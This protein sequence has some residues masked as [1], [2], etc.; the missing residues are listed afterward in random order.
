MFA[1]PGGMCTGPSVAATRGNVFAETFYLLVQCSND[2][3]GLKHRPS[4]HAVSGGGRRDAVDQAVPHVLSHPAEIR[5]G[6]A[7]AVGSVPLAVVPA[8]PRLQVPLP[9]Q[10]VRVRVAPQ[11]IPRS[12][13]RGQTVATAAMAMA[14]I[15]RKIPMVASPY[16]VSP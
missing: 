11:R 1:R 13:K 2:L 16:V 3:D 8:H 10:I 6:L 5:G 14:Q 7:D 4:R 15:P 12:S 9:L